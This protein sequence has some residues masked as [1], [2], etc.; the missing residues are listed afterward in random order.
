[1]QVCERVY[2]MNIM[3]WKIVYKSFRSIIS[4][5]MSKVIVSCEGEKWQMR[6]ATTMLYETFFVHKFQNICRILYIR[7]TQS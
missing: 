1:M 5:D 7:L 4:N 2:L 6:D 3:T